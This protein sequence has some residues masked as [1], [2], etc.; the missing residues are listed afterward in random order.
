MVN[1]HPT[2]ILC[3]SQNLGLEI[4]FLWHCKH[5]KAEGVACCCQYIPRQ[6]SQTVCM[7][8]IDKT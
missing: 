6:T 5:S 1:P 8:Q 7:Q 3:T 4:F 2:Q